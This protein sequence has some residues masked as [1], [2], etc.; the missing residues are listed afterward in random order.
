METFP[1][2]D[3][4][5]FDNN[6]Q[7]CVDPLPQD[8][9]ARSL[10][11]DSASLITKEEEDT[12]EKD[13]EQ[14]HAIDE[15]VEEALNKIQTAAGSLL[16]AREGLREFIYLLTSNIHSPSVIQ[17]WQV[18]ATKSIYMIRMLQDIVET[19][20]LLQFKSTQAAY[21]VPRLLENQWN[22]EKR[23]PRIKDTNAG[24]E[25][26]QDQS[27]SFFA[28]ILLFLSPT[29][30][31]LHNKLALHFYTGTAEK[32]ENYGPFD[33]FKRLVDNKLVGL[34]KGKMAR[35]LCSLLL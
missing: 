20:Q 21:V 4:G 33:L 5:I 32:G 16:L 6:N 25:H 14:L 9:R 35:F 15:L 3:L 27:F 17:H 1:P 29:N 10:S 28:R 7:L 22:L 8:R 26:L 23:V 18:R 13:Q 12:E 11:N 19:F 24:A 30:Q 31:Y 2:L 34:P